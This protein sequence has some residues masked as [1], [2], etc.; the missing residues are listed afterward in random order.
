MNLREVLLPR[1]KIFFELLEM[2]SNNVM[3]GAQAFREV[4]LHYESLPEKRSQIKDIE[5]RGDEI[6]QQIYE[7]LVKTFVTPLDR[8]EI[9][10]LASLYDDVLDYIE[11]VVT[12]LYLYGIEKPT[13]TMRKFADL[14]PKAVEEID[15]AFAAIHEIRAPGIETRCNAVDRL[16]HEADDLLHESVAVL[17]KSHD[18]L[19]VMK[20][21]EIYEVME[22]IIDKCADVVQV[23]RNIILEYS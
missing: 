8:E 4:I 3:L 2:E 23:I 16:E 15:F 12:R 10:K 14:V 7:Q 20:L 13:E 11:G 21:K 9:A 22:T 5:H 19:T 1:E 17:F 18:T 6:V